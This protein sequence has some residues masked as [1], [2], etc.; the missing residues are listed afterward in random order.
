MVLQDI[1]EERDHHRRLRKVH[2][3]IERLVLRIYEI[4]DMIDTLLHTISA[5]FD[6]GDIWAQLLTA[7]VKFE[8]SKHVLG[9]VEPAIVS[10]LCWALNGA[11]PLTHFRKLI[12]AVNFRCV[13]KALLDEPLDRLLPSVVVAIQE[14]K[15][16]DVPIG[17][18]E[19]G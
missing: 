9:P 2:K 11:F 7:V 1:V 10:K 8:Y 16:C 5:F 13:S 17:L 19:I 14:H 3:A 4:E 18:N 12:L 6:R 15:F